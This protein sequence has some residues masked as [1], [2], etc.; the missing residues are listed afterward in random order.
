MSFM[1]HWLLVHHSFKFSSVIGGH[2]TQSIYFLA[3]QKNK[4]NSPIMLVLSC[5]TWWVTAGYHGEKIFKKFQVKS[6][7]FAIFCE[8]SCQKPHFAKK[9]K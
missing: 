7:N 5:N 6:T 3:F 1:V 4:N 8:F 2:V 9:L